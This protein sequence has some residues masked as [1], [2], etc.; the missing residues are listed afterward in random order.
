MRTNK[1][2]RS[3]ATFYCSSI[4]DGR[5]LLFIVAYITCAV[6]GCRVPVGATDLVD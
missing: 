1:D 2:V 3:E 5:G 4:L 6:L